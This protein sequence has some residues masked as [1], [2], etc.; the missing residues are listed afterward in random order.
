MPFRLDLELTANPGWETV[1]RAIAPLAGDEVSA[2]SARS[3]ARWL[4]TSLELRDGMTG[5]LA[6]RSGVALRASDLTHWLLPNLPWCGF[7][8]ELI[9]LPSTESE[10]MVLLRKRTAR[11]HRATLFA[12]DGPYTPEG[13]ADLSD[14][15]YERST[16]DGLQTVN[17]DPQISDQA[18]LL[19]LQR[20]ECVLEGRNRG[21]GEKN[22]APPGIEAVPYGQLVGRYSH[23]LG[24]KR[25]TSRGRRTAQIEAAVRHWTLFAT[26][27]PSRFVRA[28][29]EDRVRRERAGVFWR[30]LA[31]GGHTP[32]SRRLHRLAGLLEKGTSPDD[33]QQGLDLLLELAC[34]PLMLP[35]LVEEALRAPRNQILTDIERRELIYLARAGTRDLRILA[36]ARLRPEREFPEVRSTLAQLA[37]DVDPWVRE[38]ARYPGAP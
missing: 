36:V 33:I 24:F 30:T 17:P 4:P 10:G 27:C 1:W 20:G 28:S 6:Q 5:V 25:A 37:Y 14:L 31:G 22:A 15:R 2:S 32:V 23:L 13:G 18:V 7:E 12:F 11:G 34:L 16:G 29:V 35:P 8:G 19:S 38:A 26:A 21:G 9:A 3:S